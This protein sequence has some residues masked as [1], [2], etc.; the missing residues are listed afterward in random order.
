M[1]STHLP[2][3]APT[4]R[5]ACRGEQHF[6]RGLRNSRLSRFA[7]HKTKPTPSPGTSAVKGIFSDVKL[8]SRVRRVE[9]A[10]IRDVTLVRRKPV[11]KAPPFPN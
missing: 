8:G 7:A 10:N 1:P 5:G 3:P 2:G 9:G 4:R 11:G 6:F